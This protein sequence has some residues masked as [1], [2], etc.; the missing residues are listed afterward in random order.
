MSLVAGRYRLVRSLGSGGMG[1]VALAEDTWRKGRHVA[2]KV[3]PD[4]DA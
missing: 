4:S 1:Q 2:L 3:A